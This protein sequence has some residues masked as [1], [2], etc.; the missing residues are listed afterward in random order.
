MSNS[1]LPSGDDMKTLDAGEDTN[2]LP[3]G[4]DLAIS[5]LSSSTSAPAKNATSSEEDEIAESD[6]LAQT[7]TALQNVIE[8]SARELQ[9]LNEDIKLKRESLK[10]VFDNDSQLDEAEQQ[11]QAITQQVKQRKSQLQAD[12]QV[13]ALKV[14]IG[15]INEKKK[16]IEESLSNHLV[17]YYQLTNSTSFDTSDGDQWEF[18]IKAKVKPRKGSK[19]E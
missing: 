11:A 13:T 5:A 18:A 6:K 8:R 4:D 16:E 10:N 1:Q 2:Q 3:S 14:D 15:E 12:P 17:N 19:D 9:K 7:L